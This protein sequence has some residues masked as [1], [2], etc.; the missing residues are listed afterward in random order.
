MSSGH[1][2]LPTY[3]FEHKPVENKRFGR[4]EAP[5]SS[6]KTRNFKKVLI[7]LIKSPILSILIPFTP[8]SIQIMFNWLKTRLNEPSTYQGITTVAAAAGFTINPEAWEAIVALA[9]GIIGFIQMIKEDKK[10]IEKKK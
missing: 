9:A 6:K 3:G 7:K 2:K 5:T 1:T 8:K 4:V 10:I